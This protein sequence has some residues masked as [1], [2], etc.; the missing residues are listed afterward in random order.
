MWKIHI[1]ID[2]QRSDLFDIGRGFSI[3]I[4][5]V[6]VSVCCSFT[7]KSIWD[8]RGNVWSSWKYA[9]KNLQLSIMTYHEFDVIW[10]VIFGVKK[11]VPTSLTGSIFWRSLSIL[12]LYS[13]RIV[14]LG[15]LE[16]TKK[17]RF[18]FLRTENNTSLIYA[19]H[20]TC[21]LMHSQTKGRR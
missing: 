7:G 16:L 1:R 8:G 14:E 20:L 17:K 2:L 4:A 19:C 9:Y 5:G 10:K 6:V 18:S 12:C 13:L 3:W 21:L 15:R 11:N